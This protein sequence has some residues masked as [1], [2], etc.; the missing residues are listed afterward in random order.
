MK[1]NIVFLMSDQ[2]NAKCLGSY[3][4]NMVKTPNL[5]KLAARGVRLTSAFTQNPICTPSRVCYLSGQYP[6]NHGYFGLGGPCPENIPSIYAHLKSSGYFTGLIGKHH[7]P[8]GWV[9]PHLDFLTSSV[10][11]GINQGLMTYNAYLK[12]NGVEDPSDFVNKKREKEGK[13]GQS[14]DGRPDIL[15]K[16]LSIDGYFVEM[17]RE[18][19]EKRPQDKPF[20][21]LFSLSKPHQE[22][23]PAKEFW[24]LYPEEMPMPP[25]ADDSDHKIAP[26]R[27]RA[28]A[29]RNTPPADLEPGDYQSLRKRKLRGYYG[30]ISHMDWA[31]GEVIKMVEDAGLTENTIIVYSTDH[32]DFA[33]EY[34]ILEKAPGISSDAIGRIPQIWSWPGHLPENEVRDQLIETIDLWPTLARLANIPD[35]EMWDGKDLTDILINNGQEVRESAL[36]EFPFIKSIATKK[37][38][39]TY[40]PQNMFPGDPVQGELYDREN[41]P[42]E[43]KNLF[44]APQYEEIVKELKGKLMDLLITT[45]HPVTVQPIFTGSQDVLSEDGKI[46]PNKIWDYIKNGGTSDYL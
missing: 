33:C 15:P 35:L 18:F 8:E 5:D 17:T 10:G 9:E 22:Y 43:M 7:L 30:N 16:E 37:W 38:R 32:G 39:M 4:H 42:W 36:T 1:P 31:M 25:N 24:D 41:D 21:L 34:G 13:G 23:K 27:A 26:V 20:F 29:Q 46:S 44:H 3:G 28:A 12:S 45:S 11:G 2:H 6:H 40:L 14:V 19:I